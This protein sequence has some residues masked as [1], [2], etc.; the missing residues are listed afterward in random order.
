MTV[1]LSHRI[2]WIFIAVPASYRI[3]NPSGP[4]QGMCAGRDGTR[5][6]GC[7]YYPD[8]TGT[9]EFMFATRPCLGSSGPKPSVSVGDNSTHYRETVYVRP[10]PGSCPSKE[11]AN[12]TPKPGARLS[13]HAS[14]THG[15]T[16][17]AI[18]LGIPQNKSRV[19]ATLLASSLS[20]GGPRV[21][22]TDLLANRRAGS[23]SFIVALNATGQSMLNRLRKL[24]VTLKVA[25]FA[26]GGKTMTATVRLY[27]KKRR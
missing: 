4:S 19:R 8:A 1:S 14:P 15:G 12:T 11:R 10:P 26:S 9:L 27:L 5:G 16:A 20:E 7:V 22:G 2:E 25:V 23:T 21:V 13:L 24:L 18:R 17:V 3:E 6:F